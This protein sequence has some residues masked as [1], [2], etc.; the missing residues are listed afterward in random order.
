MQNFIIVFLAGIVE[1]ITKEI[2]LKVLSAVEFMH[3][4]GLVHRNIKAENILIFD[5]VHFSR[6]R[7][8]EIKRNIKIV[9]TIKKILK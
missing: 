1:S 6:V 3:S 7:K 8:L 9:K 2:M 5:N 4:E